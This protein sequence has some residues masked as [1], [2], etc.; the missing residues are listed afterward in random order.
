M[1]TAA[2][3]L[4]AFSLLGAL[5]VYGYGVYWAPNS[6]DTGAAP[7]A[8][9]TAPGIENR[10]PSRILIPRLSIDAEVQRL[11]LT[12][13]GNMAAPNNF[14]DTSWYKFGTLPGDVGSAVIAGH[15]DNALGLDGVFKHLE[16]LSLGDDIYILAEDG[17]RTHFQVVDKKLFPYDLAGPELEQ[18]FH[19]DDAAR[20]NLITCAGS[21]LPEA[22]T[23]DQRL[24]VYTKRV[25]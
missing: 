20:L 21:W 2:K 6:E 23:N 16:D 15:E 1:R 10:L 18:V 24:V 14:V 11:G 8:S 25:N 9:V 3:L 22:H 19:A 17:T 13:T 12:K 7:T 4:I 5:L